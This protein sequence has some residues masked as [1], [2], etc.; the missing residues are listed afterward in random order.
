MLAEHKAAA[1]DYFKDPDNAERVPKLARLI[2]GEELADN[3]ENGRRGAIRPSPS[4]MGSLVA[5]CVRADY[6]VSGSPTV[7][8]AELGS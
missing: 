6:G 2:N 5:P 7:H 4:Q 8:L 3:R 1:R